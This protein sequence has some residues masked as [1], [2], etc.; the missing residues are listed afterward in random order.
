MADPLDAWLADFLVDTWGACR[1]NCWR[2]EYVDTCWL[3]RLDLLTLGWLRRWL[4]LWMRGWLVGLVEAL[5]A[6]P[7]ELLAESLDVW[8]A[9]QAESLTASSVK[10]VAGSLDAWLA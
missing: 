3:G 1:A 4:S 5:D 10:F 8:L 9:E 6:Q 2:G 7:A